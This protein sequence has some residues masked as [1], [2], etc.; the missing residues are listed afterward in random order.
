MKNIITKPTACRFF[1]SG[2]FMY[3]ISQDGQTLTPASL[4]DAPP[5]QSREGCH[6]HQDGVSLCKVR[7]LYNE[8]VTCNIPLNLDCV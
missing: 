8:N 3:M 2:F 6:A 5:L 1:V 4:C 7:M